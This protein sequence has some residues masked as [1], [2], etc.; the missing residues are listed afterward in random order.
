[1]GLIRVVRALFPFVLLISGCAKTPISHVATPTSPCSIDKMN[2]EAQIPWPRNRTINLV[3]HGHSVPAG[4]FKTPQV[5]T[6][7]AYPSRTLA[8]LSKRYPLAQLNAIVTARGGE[9]SVQGASRFGE[10]LQHR[11]DVVI[12]DYVLNDRQLSLA[13]SGAAISEMVSRARKAGAC[14][15][16]ATASPDLSADADTTRRLREH[17]QQIRELAA[18][19]GALLLDEEAIFTNIPKEHISKYMAQA[20]HPNELGHILIADKLA[21]LL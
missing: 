21:S 9:N 12:V 11:P 20:N 16:L 5:R 15:V 3:F 10:A 1:M 13:E 19:N 18:N 6:M 14:V 7:D 8:L 17:S 4:F 2:L